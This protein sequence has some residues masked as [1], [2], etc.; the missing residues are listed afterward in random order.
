MALDNSRHFAAVSAAALGAVALV[1]AGCGSETAGTV[2]SG[3][4]PESASPSSAQS[5]AGWDLLYLSDSSGWKVAEAY[6]QL[7]EQHLGVP[8]RLIDARAGN[9]T[10]GDD[11]RWIESNPSSV[12]T[13]EIVVLEGAPYGSGV[14]ES[15]LTCGSAQ[16]KNP[17][18]AAAEDF[19]PYRDKVAEALDKIWDARSG[20]PTVVRV[21]DI[22]SPITAEYSAAGILDE[23]THIGELMSDAVRAAAQE[24]GA[25]MVSALEALNGPDHTQDADALG[26]IGYDGIHLSEAGGRAV[27]EALAAAGFEPTRAP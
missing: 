18:A 24:H 13:A 11:I 21:T 14:D 25:T 6:Q 19:V 26:Y 12:A 3:T 20:T 23:C 9:R 10:I 2:D 7:A 15:L 8:V 5:D 22:Y 17:G 1:L 16:P 27:A 4:S